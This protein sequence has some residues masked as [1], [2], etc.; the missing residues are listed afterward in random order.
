MAEDLLD[1]VFEENEVIYRDNIGFKVGTRRK[2]TTGILRKDRRVETRDEYGHLEGYT[3]K[4]E[5]LFDA[6][7]VEFRDKDDNVVGKADACRG[8]LMQYCGK[9][10]ILERIN[11]YVPPPLCGLLFS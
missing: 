3:V 5:P 9:R 10:S 1:L 4:V 6:P 2:T 8:I 7:Y 11:P